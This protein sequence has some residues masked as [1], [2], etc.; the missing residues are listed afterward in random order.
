MKCLACNKECENR[1]ELAY[2][3]NHEHGLN[4]KEYKLRYQPDKDDN[5]LECPICHRYNMKQLTQHI[6]SAHKLTKD[7]FLEQFPNTKLWIE[8]IST[9][10]SK[11]QSIG[12]QTYRDNL[13]NDPH[14]YDE[15]YAR[16]TEKRDIKTFGEKVRKTRIERG[17][18]EAMSKR[19]VEMWKDE[20]YRKFQSEKT[21]RQHKNGLT[22]KVVN[23]HIGKVY[24]REIG[25]KV[26]YF[27]SSWEVELAKYFYENN[28]EFEYEPFYIEY[29]FKD[30]THRYYPDFYLKEKNLLIEVKPFGLITDEKV[31]NKKNACIEQGYKFMFITENELKAINSVKFE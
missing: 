1:Q 22:D 28:I 3:I 31:I 7:E 26:Y 2:H 15:S 17:T 29:I 16:R 12:I 18:N 19:L 27:K 23:R 11:A 13:K 24:F 5:L 21:K 30:E 25:E 4:T 6:T 8:E 10:C 20:D 14:Y 9:R